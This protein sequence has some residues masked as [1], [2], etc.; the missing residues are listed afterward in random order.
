VPCRATEPTYLARKVGSHSTLFFLSAAACLLAGAAPPASKAQEPEFETL[1]SHR[2]RVEAP[3]GADPAGSLV[4]VPLPA[5]VLAVADEDLSDL[6]FVAAGDVLPYVLDG[7]RKPGRLVESYPAVLVSLEQQALPEEAPE[8]DSTGQLARRISEVMT[9]R[10]PPPGDGWRLVASSSQQRFV[11]RVRVLDLNGSANSSPNEWQSLFRLQRPLRELLHVPVGTIASATRTV[12]VELQGSEPA[13]EPTWRWE[14]WEVELAEPGEVRSIVLERLD[15]SEA[16]FERPPA[17]VPEALVLRTRETL[18]HSSVRVWDESSGGDRR[19][20]SEG[21]LLRAADAE[22]LVLPLQTPPAGS[23]LHLQFDEGDAP[24]PFAFELV[25]RVRPP[26]ALLAWPLEAS[27]VELLVGGARVRP[28]AGELVELSR[29]LAGAENAAAPWGPLGP[30]E[31]SAL[32]TLLDADLPSAKVLRLERNPHYID[33]P[34]LQPLLRP[35]AVIEP[36][37]F[38]HR[39][40]LVLESPPDGLSEVELA[41]GD[42]AVLRPDLGD[43]RVVDES[44]QQWPF[45]IR[46]AERGQR[47]AVELRPL[48]SSEGNRTEYRLHAAWSPLPSTGLSV[49]TSQPFFDR[50]VRVVAQLPDGSEQTLLDTRWRREVGE[51]VVPRLSWPEARCRSLSL[52]VDNGDDAPLALDAAWLHLPQPIVQLVAPAGN[53]QLLLGQPALEAPTYEALGARL[54]LLQTLRA[55]AAKPLALEANPE[56]VPGSRIS[57]ALSEPEPWFWMA[58]VLAV[59]VLSFFIL[60]ATKTDAPG[61]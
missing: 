6:R 32:R 42:L 10:A 14:R 56:F 15:G 11:R 36:R 19:I 48:P 40:L 52:W 39:R 7:R 61:T 20:V 44:F 17:V 51:A 55:T 4:R 18:V 30:S 47:Q 34:R 49:A 57:A 53:Y 9:L 5:E 58:I 31:E 25:A 3:P 54:L 24:P 13:L 1:F 33:T 16:R 8:R 50:R 22:G 29:L 60:R 46:L 37:R 28:A 38:S 35:G 59:V 45:R 21:L 23:V 2:A 41:P 26:I 12:V 27:E 43:L